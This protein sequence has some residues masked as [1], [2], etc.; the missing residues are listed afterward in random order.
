MPQPNESKSTLKA[1]LIIGAVAVAVAL[2]IW[3]SATPRKETAMS[4]AQALEQELVMKCGINACVEPDLAIN[5]TTQ[6]MYVEV[7]KRGAFHATNK[8]KGVYKMAAKTA[9]WSCMDTGRW[10]ALCGR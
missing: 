7:D 10:A 1:I 4:K 2:S 8:R 6:P 3:N 5:G 9:M